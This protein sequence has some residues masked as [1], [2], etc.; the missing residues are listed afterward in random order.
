MSNDIMNRAWPIQLPV[1]EKLILMTLSDYA[2]DDGECFPS[3]ASIAERACMDARRVYRLLKNLEGAQQI[4]RRSRPGHSTVYV[5]HP[6]PVTSATPVTQTTG[7]GDIPP[8]SPL[9]PTPVTTATPITL[10]P[11]GTSDSR[12]AASGGP[13]TSGTRDPAGEEAL[14]ESTLDKALF[15]EARKI[16][17]YSIGG[18]VNRAIRAKGK[19]WVHGVIEACRGKDEEAARAYFAAA[20]RG[21]S[22]PDEAQQRK[23]IP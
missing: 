23:A 6:T 20:L 4:S 9:P 22:K 12:R 21:V 14:P 7:L 19:P 8:L 18:Q 3:I 5:I 2:N 1:P 16:F 11:Q 17:G 15:A 13:N 10:N